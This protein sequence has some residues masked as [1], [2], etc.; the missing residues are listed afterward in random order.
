MSLPAT[1]RA[2]VLKGDYQVAVEDRPVPKIQKPTDAILKVSSTALCGSDLHFYRGH[3]KCPPN[4]ICGHEFVGTI[5]EKGDAVKNFNIGDKVVV[6][7]YTACQECYYC[8]RGQASR[9]LHGE[10][11]GN[12]VP[13]NTVDGGQAE[14]VRVPLAG[15]TCVKAPSGIPEEMLVLMADIFPTGYFAAARFL[16]D[17][18]QRDRD[19]FTTVVIGC[20]PVGICAI[21][22]ALTMVKT[23]YA[24]DSVPERLAEAEKIGAI[25][26]NLND[27][28]V[29]KIKA[30]SGGRGADVVLEVVGHA[31][32]FMLAFDMIRPWGQISS[33]GVHT[34]MIPLNGLLC[35]G[36]NVTMAFGRCPVRSIFEDALKILI[37]EQKKVAHLCGKTMSLE[38]APQAYKDFEARKVM[39]IVFKMPGEATGQNVADKV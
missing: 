8:V 28:P 9:C 2:V 26:I 34:E 13:A 25:P 33:I 39:K 3:L 19:E 24:I 35:Y 18:P 22:S 16:K 1:M 21:T 10:L 31:D 38:D 30:A 20:G 23:V 29:E 37:K 11:F 5:V 12:S 6:P 17:L 4:F 14:Y 15:T 27:N 32:A 36:K 7:F